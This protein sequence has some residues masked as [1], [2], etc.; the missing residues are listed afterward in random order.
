LVPLI[1]IRLAAQPVAAPAQAVQPTAQRIVLAPPP[2]SQIHREEFSLLSSVRELSNGDVLVADGRERRLVR[3][4]FSDGSTLPIGRVGRGPREFLWLG[5]LLACGRDSTIFDDGG[6]RRWAVLRKDSLIDL[7]P[8][9]HPLVARWSPF[10]FGADLK[11]NLLVLPRSLTRVPDSAGTTVDSAPVVLA[12]LRR[13]A[14]RVPTFLRRQATRMVGST[15]GKAGSG[16][17]ETPVGTVFGLN[18]DEGA[19]MFSDG[20]IAIAR[21]HPFR[22]DFLDPNGNW[23]RGDSLPVSPIRVD[24]AERQSY[25]KRNEKNYA[26]GEF[27]PPAASDF[28]RFL[29]SFVSP[30]TSLFTAPDGS[31]LVQRARN[32]RMTGNHYW[33]VDRNTRLVGEVE[34][35]SNVKITGSSDKYVYVSVRDDDDVLRL[36]RYAWPINARGATRH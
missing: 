1:A 27:K 3:L 25:L 34:L 6:N 28:P 15:G 20:W 17:T 10:L 13:N 12:S 23:R 18:E 11:G 33:L 36:G 8:P 30:A 14:V 24:A 2:T 31:V 26:S 21:I 32:S 9:D 4:R 7:L 35:P 5:R 29:P 22:V 16:F 19:I